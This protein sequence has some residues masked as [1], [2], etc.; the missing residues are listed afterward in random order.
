MI[1]LARGDLP[2]T[3]AEDVRLDRVVA[4]SVARAKRDFPHVR[5]ETAFESVIVEGVPER[6]ARAVNNLLD[7]AAHHSP[8]DGLVEVVV[9][10]AGVRV[11]DHG[12]GIDEADLPYV[13]D[14]FY[15]GANSRNRQGSGLGLAIVRQVATQHGGSIE[16]ANAPDGGAMFTLRLPTVVEESPEGIAGAEPRGG[17]FALAALVGAAPRPRAQ[18]L[19]GRASRAWRA[20]RKRRR[21]N[22]AQAPNTAA[23]GTSSSTRTAGV[24]DGQHDQELSHHGRESPPAGPCASDSPRG[25]PGRSPRSPRA[26]RGPRRRSSAGPPWRITPT[27]R[28]TVPAKIASSE[29]GRPP[30]GLGGRS[31]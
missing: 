22:Q 24:P 14:R 9:D 31:P 11:R 17:G 4:E 15:R 6:L 7:N 1:E 8:R 16:A 29:T 10:R 27:I 3:S 25:A 21:R 18:R 26:G 20:T 30:N 13:F 2:I 28:A 12:T 19:S 23:T 5:F